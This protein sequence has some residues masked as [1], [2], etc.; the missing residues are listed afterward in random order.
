MSAERHLRS[1]PASGAATPRNILILC[2][3]PA[4]TRELLVLAR[5]MCSDGRFRPVLLTRSAE[6]EAGLT[7][8]ELAA[9]E[10]LRIPLEGTAAQGPAA[11]FGRLLMAHAVPFGVREYG[12]M[13]RRFE[14][15]T[16]AVRRG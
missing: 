13:R 3:G 14:A 7:H 9:F 11:R 2:E 5:A 1:E 6:S 4:P 12:K 10:V 16:G 15:S 8:Q